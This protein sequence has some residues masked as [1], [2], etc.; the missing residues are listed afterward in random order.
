MSKA[1]LLLADGF[2][3]IEA[4]TP[5]DVLR[6]CGIEVITVSINNTNKVISSHKIMVESDIFLKE[7]NI[8]SVLDGDMI[9]LPGGYPGYI[10]LQNSKEVSSIIKDYYKNNKYIAAICGGPTVIAK[11]NIAKGCNITCH[12]SVRDEMSDYII[13][14]EYDKYQGVIIDGKIIT[15]IGAGHS[16]DFSLAI[17][18]ILSDRATV[19]SV[20]KKMEI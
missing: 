3:T 1:Y 15:G 18:E 20:M 11:N 2:E 16:L 10:N 17:A 19:E 6:R 12:T 8:D 14:K 9:I 4:L 13:D 7:N 5:I